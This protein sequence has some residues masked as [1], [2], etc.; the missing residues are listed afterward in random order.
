MK[1]II[2]VIL[3]WTVLCGLCACGAAE[4]DMQDILPQTES[5]ATSM[6]TTMNTPSTE[7]TM[8]STMSTQTD[9]S[10]TENTETTGSPNSLARSGNAGE[11]PATVTSAYATIHIPEGMTYT[12]H[13]GSQ[14]AGANN[15]RL[16]LNEMDR[17]ETKHFEIS[18]RKTVNSTDDAVIECVRMNARGANNE[19]TY[20]DDVKLGDVTYKAIHIVNDDGSAADYLVTYFRHAEGADVYVEMK[21]AEYPTGSV[22]MP[23]E[24][25]KVISFLKNIQYTGKM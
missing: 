2:A 10:T 8:P 20:G 17:E 9:G 1:T 25:S 23:L 22:V 5:T 14:V 16:T 4:S 18:E 6:S 21:T 12:V 13:H 3:T 7:A 11:G 24:D 15:F 19:V